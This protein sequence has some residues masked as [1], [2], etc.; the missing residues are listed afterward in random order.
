[1]AVI[2]DDCIA[3]S[4][5]LTVILDTLSAH[6]SPDVVTG[7]V[8]P[9]EPVGERVC[10]VASR[11]SPR[12]AEFVGK[13]MP[14]P[15]GS[16]NNFA[17]KREWFL[18]IGGCDERL[19]PG[20][21]GQGGVDLD[22]FYRLLRAGA[23]I[24]YEPRSLVYH[25][26]DTRAGRLARRP[27]YGHGMGVCCV[28]RLREGDLFAVRMFVQ[29]MFMRSRKLAGGARRRDWETVKEETLMLSGTLRGLWHGMWNAAVNRNVRGVASRGSA[30]LP[31]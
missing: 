27:M 3:D 28:L 16:G 9:L 7:R 14:W 10:P 1:M 11:V 25:E 12:A 30:S 20:S 19:G 23:C 17:L 8:L 26:R 18:R 6:E 15:V 4:E 21:P 5:W 13:T 2:D 24:R 29:W 31:R 22:L